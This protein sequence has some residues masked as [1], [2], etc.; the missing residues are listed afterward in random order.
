MITTLTEDEFKTVKRAFLEL[1][2]FRY[3]KML[4]RTDSEELINK[5][6]NILTEKDIFSFQKQI[7]E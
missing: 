1:N 7:K 2:S 5:A 6:L 4:T 3:T